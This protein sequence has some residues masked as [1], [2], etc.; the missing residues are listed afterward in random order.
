MI[1]SLSRTLPE[2]SNDGYVAAAYIVFFAIVLIYVAIM[3]VRLGR[4]ERKV[5]ALRVD[6][7]KSDIPPRARGGIADLDEPNPRPER[8]DRGQEHALKGVPHGG[9]QAGETV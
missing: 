9:G 2:H 3:A 8:P 4:V 7:T 6:A 1:A 5:E